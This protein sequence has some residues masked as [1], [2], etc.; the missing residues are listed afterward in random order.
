MAHLD[1][2]GEATLATIPLMDAL[3]TSIKVPGFPVSALPRG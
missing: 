3:L 2:F 1:G